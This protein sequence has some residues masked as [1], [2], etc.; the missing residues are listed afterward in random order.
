MNME[1][2][3]NN[4][5]K[6]AE[7]AEQAAENIKLSAF[8]NPIYREPVNL[9]PKIDYTDYIT[10]RTETKETADFPKG[11]FQNP[12]FEI[13]VST[14]SH[15]QTETSPESILLK[16]DSDMASLLN[17]QIQLNHAID[18]GTGVMTAMHVVESAQA[19]LDADRKLYNELISAEKAGAGTGTKDGNAQNPDSGANG[20]Q[21]GA[22]IGE[23][24]LGSVSHAQWELERAY[25]SGSQV[26]IQNAKR[27]LA[28][29]KAKE[30]A[31]KMGI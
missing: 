22:D 19:V 27:H 16:I 11:V 29:E 10:D 24:K 2:I 9:M 30:D 21:Q 7:A 14:F 18:R 8:Q 6:M 5:E 26:A 13:D 17:A 23:K 1:I 3:D 28:E 25:K 31:K 4:E 20:G 12:S 15:D